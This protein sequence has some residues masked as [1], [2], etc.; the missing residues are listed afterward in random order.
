VRGRSDW[1]HVVVVDH[2]GKWVHDPH[3]RGNGA[4]LTEVEGYFVFC[5]PYEPF[6]D[7]PEEAERAS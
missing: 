6:P 3:P 4:W 1:N 7:E 5:Q 2:D